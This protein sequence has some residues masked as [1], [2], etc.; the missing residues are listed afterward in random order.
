[1]ESILTNAMVV[2]ISRSPVSS[3]SWP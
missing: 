1:M 3:R 2:E